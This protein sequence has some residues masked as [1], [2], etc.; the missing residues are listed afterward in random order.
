MKKWIFI[1]V[2]ALTSLF[3]CE[4][5]DLTERTVTLLSPP[6]N[7]SDS[8][9]NKLFWWEEVTGAS[10]YQFQIVSPSFDSIVTLVLDSTL[11][12]TKFEKTLIPGTY[13][14]RVR[15]KNGST[16]TAW[17]TYNLEVKNTQSLAGQSITNMSPINKYISSDYAVNFSWDALAKA[18]SYVFKI[19]DSIGNT[20]LPNQSLTTASTTHTF[21]ADGTYIW[22]V[23][24]LNSLSASLT[25]EHTIYIDKTAPNKP[26]LSKPTNGETLTFPYTF[27]WSVGVNK[28][29]ALTDSIWIATDSL[30]TDIVLDTVVAKST[31][32]HIPSLNTLATKLFWKVHSRDAAGNSG[33]YSAVWTFIK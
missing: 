28:G 8:I 11:T 26:S 32:V 1:Y 18:S 24:G 12:K 29:T 7:Q 22:S 16:A 6:N 9:L 15:A 2:L 3:A 25:G 10:K 23:Q 17:R 4:R 5:F 21:V 33:P 30:F 19:R 14:W 20:I 27:Q 31:T 13:Q